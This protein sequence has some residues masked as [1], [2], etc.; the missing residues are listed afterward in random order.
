MANYK[1]RIRK[2]IKMIRNDAGFSQRALSLRL[3][4]GQTFI[5]RNELGENDVTVET[6][7]DICRECNVNPVDA[8]KLIMEGDLDAV[9]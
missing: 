1:N 2:A 8:M 4:M 9:S 3:D 5:A 6:L 7:I